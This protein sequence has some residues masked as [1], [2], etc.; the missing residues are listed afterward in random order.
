MDVWHKYDLSPI[1]SSSE[2]WHSTFMTWAW[3]CTPLEAASYSLAESA[4]RTRLRLPFRFRPWGKR[5]SDLI[6]LIRDVEARSA[7]LQIWQN[8]T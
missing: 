8:Y 6:H 3:Y 5:T 7:P 4:A 2:T 1:A